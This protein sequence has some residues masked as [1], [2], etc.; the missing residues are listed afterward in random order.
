MSRDIVDQI[1][2]ANLF[3]VFGGS[4]DGPS[5]GGPLIGDGVKVVEY[6]LLNL[7][8]DFLHLT[9]NDT[10]FSLNLSLSEV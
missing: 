2:T 5:K 8:V 3:N 7:L 9:Q 10:T 6:H 4:E 1:L